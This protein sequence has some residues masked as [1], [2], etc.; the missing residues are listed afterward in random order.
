M[1]DSVVT[2]AGT[3]DIFAFYAFWWAVPSEDRGRV[4]AYK[5]GLAASGIEY[6]DILM[7]FDPVGGI[8]SPIAC[9]AP[10]DKTLD[11]PP[12]FGDLPGG[13]LPGG[14]RPGDSPAP[15]STRRRLNTVGGQ[16]SA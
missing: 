16:C 9:Q 14:P 6:P 7:P 4:E 10:F 3:F 1:A 2:Q 15:G 11:V 8:P 12:P 5:A 13:P